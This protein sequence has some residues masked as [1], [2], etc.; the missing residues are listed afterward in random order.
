MKTYNQ[1]KSEDLFEYK[2]GSFQFF[3]NPESK[4]GKDSFIVQEKLNYIKIDT[5]GMNTLSCGNGNEA[6]FSFEIN[7]KIADDMIKLLSKIK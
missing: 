3:T 2:S 4:S 7:K 6:F 1:F 5:V